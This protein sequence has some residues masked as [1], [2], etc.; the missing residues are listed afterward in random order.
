[1]KK[2]VIFDIDGTI[3]DCWERRKKAAHD[4]KGDFNW[5]VFND[6]VEIAK[7]KPVA[8]VVELFNFYKQNYDVYFVSG[9]DETMRETTKNWLYL[10][11]IAGYT[12]MYLRADKD[13]RSDVV[14]KS[15]IY[16]KHFKDKE[17]HLVLDDRNSVVSMWR[18]LGLKCFQVQEGDF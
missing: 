17:V 8:Q 2:V 18:R 6:P 11:G 5:K 15:E 12:D 9:R 14:I 7:D 13:Y 4:Y 3:A 10:N 16:E 1:M